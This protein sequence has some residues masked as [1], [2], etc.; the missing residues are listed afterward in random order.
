MMEPRERR[1]LL[2]TSRNPAA[3]LDY[4]VTLRGHLPGTG[5]AEIVLRYVPDRLVLPPG[6]FGRYLAALDD[7]GDGLEALAA[8]V[9]DDILNELVPRWVEVVARRHGEP[10]QDVLLVEHQPGWANEALLRRLDPP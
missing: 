4:V 10:R 9:L 1:Q 7:A 6:V 2:E 8:A 3:R 5:Q